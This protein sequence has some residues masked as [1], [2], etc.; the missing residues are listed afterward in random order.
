MVARGGEW[1]WCNPLRTDDKYPEQPEPLRLTESSQASQDAVEF[2]STSFWRLSELAPM[3]SEPDISLVHLPSSLRF[4]ILILRAPF[5]IIRKHP[6]SDVCS[7]AVV[8]IGEGIR[9]L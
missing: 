6:M 2:G 8:A 7:A 5:R 1:A 9:S 4:T 3:D